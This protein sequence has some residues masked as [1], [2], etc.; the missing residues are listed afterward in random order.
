MWIDLNADVGEGLPE[1]DASIVPL[2]SSANIA[3]GGHAGDAET[4]ALTVA[5]AI[6]HG[7]AVGA[8]PGYPDRAGFG[9][10]DLGLSSVDLSA[11]LFEQLA[12]IAEVAAAAGTVI[13]HMKVHGALYGCAARDRAIA[14]VVVDASLAVVPTALL[15]GPPDSELLAAGSQ[16]GLRVAAEGFADRAYEAD[17]SL[18]RRDLPGA[19]LPTSEAVAAQALEIVLRGRAA[20]SDGGWVNVRAE[21]LCLHGDTPGAI[22]NAL[23]VRRALEGAGVTVARSAAA[24]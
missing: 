5:L 15:V 24:S 3:C 1:V 23:A 2:L 22:E 16:A 7:V 14:G 13:D 4:M 11:S 21:T 18:R 6:E 17:G 9:R 19:L 12:A 10:R 8:H 20:L